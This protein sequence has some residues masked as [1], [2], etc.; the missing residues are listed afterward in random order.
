MGYRDETDY[1]SEGLEDC[2]INL[3][4]LPVGTKVKT[5]IGGLYQLEKVT[6]HKGT[7]A[8][9]YSFFN[10]YIPMEQHEYYEDGRLFR[11]AT[12]LL[13]IKEIIKE[14]KQ[15]E[16]KV[17]QLVELAN[18]K[19]ARIVR[20]C[21]QNEE[22]NGSYFDV[23]HFD[24]F[25]YFH[26]KE[27]KCCGD[28]ADYLNI[29]KILEEQSE[30]ENIINLKVGQKVKLRNGSFGYVDSKLSKDPKDRYEISNY[31]YSVYLE[32]RKINT[33]YTKYGKYY[34]NGLESE[35]DVIE[36]IK[37][38]EQMGQAQPLNNIIE[39]HGTKWE[40]THS[41]SSEDMVKKPNHKILFA[42]EELGIEINNIQIIASALSNERFI[43]YILGQI[44]DYRFRAG[45]KWD[46]LEE[47]IQ[48]ADYLMELYHK[49]KRLNTDWGLVKQ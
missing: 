31:D 1:I 19:Q 24:G 23:D 30:E 29:V 18:G 15:M 11:S 39:A 47:D 35:F 16:L 13:D 48:K 42:D 32:S 44:I 46:K 33:G 6:T 22:D 9:L 40:V 36:I 21:S 3:K 20:R 37:E 27:G 7:G 5:R 41:V 34:N 8:A 10:I 38:E 26:T 49:Y 25:T 28:D 4:G 14:E 43:G 2:N 45:K 17:G 12:S